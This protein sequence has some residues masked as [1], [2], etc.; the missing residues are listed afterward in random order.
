MKARRNW[1]RKAVRY[2]CETCG[3]RTHWFRIA[4]LHEFGETI[5]SWGA[6]W[7]QLHLRVD[8]RGAP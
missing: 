2:T 4:A 6:W 1:T 7:T 3:V 8:H 5:E